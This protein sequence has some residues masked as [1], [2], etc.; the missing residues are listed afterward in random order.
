MN[1]SLVGAYNIFFV[2][3]VCVKGNTLVSGQKHAVKSAALDEHPQYE[4]HF[5]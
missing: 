5:S 4:Y 3:T 2:T 1:R